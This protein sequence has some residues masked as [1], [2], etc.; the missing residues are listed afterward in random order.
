V[1]NP[2]LSSLIT[3]GHILGRGLHHSLGKSS[4]RNLHLLSFSNKHEVMHLLRCENDA[5]VDPGGKVRILEADG[6]VTVQD[7]LPERD[8]GS[9]PGASP[10]LPTTVWDDEAAA[11]A[12]GAGM[13]GP[14]M[15]MQAG[16]NPNAVRVFVYAL[17]EELVWTVIEEMGLSES[18]RLTGYAPGS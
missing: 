4:R 1:S 16:G 3:P 12:A 8:A 14:R 2:T 6:S 10:T 15:Q 5:D 17:E 18:L 9:S 13:P 11:R 7:H